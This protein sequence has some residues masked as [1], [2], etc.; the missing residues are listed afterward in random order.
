LIDDGF[1]RVSLSRIDQ[2]SAVPA[3]DHVSGAAD[4]TVQNGDR[5]R[6]LGIESSVSVEL[7]IC[8]KGSRDSG[9]CAL[10]RKCRSGAIKN[11]SAI[12]YGPGPAARSSQVELVYSESPC[13]EV[14]RLGSRSGKN[15]VCYVIISI[16]DAI[17]RLQGWVIPVSGC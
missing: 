10:V 8:G 15:K 3:N 4:D 6:I 5:S 9:R 2:K 14:D 13:G 12:G 16:R 1:S 7:Q 11:E 17:R